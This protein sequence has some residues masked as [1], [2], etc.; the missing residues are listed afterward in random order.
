MQQEEG[1]DKTENAIVKSVIQLK[2][3]TVKDHYTKIEDKE[4][5][6]MLDLQTKVDRDLLEEIYEKGYSRIPVYDRFRKDI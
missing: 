1:L 2:D 3:Q 5:C 6:Y 4:A